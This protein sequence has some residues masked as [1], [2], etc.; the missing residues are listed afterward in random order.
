MSYDD[1]DHLARGRPTPSTPATGSGGSPRSRAPTSS[2]CRATTRRF[3]VLGA[4]PPP[5]TCRRPTTPTSSSRTSSSTGSRSPAPRPTTSRCP[6]TTTS[7]RAAPSSRRRTGILGTRYSPADHLRQRPVLLARPSRRHR[8]ARPP[9]WSRRAV[10]LQPHLARRPDAR[11]PRRRRHR[12]RAGAR[13]TS[14]GTSVTHASEY[15]LQVGTQPNFTVGTFESCRVAGTTYT[16]G[17]VRRQHHRHPRPAATNEDCEPADRR[18]STTGG[19][20]RSTARSRKARR[21]PGRAGPLLR[22]PGLLLPAPAASPTCRPPAGDR[23]RADPHVGPGHRR[24]DLRGQDRAAQRRQVVDQRRRT[25]PSYTPAGHG[26]ARPGRQPV[27][28]ARHGHQHQGRRVRH[29]QQLTFNVS[30]NLPTSG[31]GAL[32]PLDPDAVHARHH[33]RAVADVGADAGRR[34]TTRSTSATAADTDQIWFGHAATDLF[35][36]SVPYPAMTDTSPRLLLPGDVRLAG[37]RLRPGQPRDRHGA[38]GPFHRRSRSRSTT[39]HAVALRRPAARRQLRRHRRTPC[40]PGDRRCTVPSTPVLKWTPDPRV[41]VLHGLRQRGRQLHQPAGAE[42][43]ASRRRPTPCT[44][45]TLD[46][47]RLTPT[48]TA[49]P[50]RRLLLAHP[51]VPQPARTADPTRCRPTDKAQ[52]TLHEALAA[53][54][55]SASIDACRHRDHLQRGTTTSTPTSGAT[56]TLGA[57]RREPRRRRPSST[58][59]RSTTTRRSPAAWSTTASWTRPTYTAFDGL[60]PEGTLFWRVQA[61][62]SDDNGLAWSAR[63]AQH[64]SFIKASPQVTLTSPVD[65]ATVAGTTPF[66]WAPQAFASSYDIEVYKNND[67]TYST[68]NRVASATGAQDSRLRPDR[69]PAAVERTP[70][71]LARAP[72]RTPTATRVRGPRPDGS[73]GQ[74]GRSSCWPRLRTAVQCPQRAG[75]AVAPCDGARNYDVTVDAAATGGT[76]VSPRAPW[77]RRTPPQ[78]ELR[79]RRPTGGR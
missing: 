43:R 9:P 76:S 18:A 44:R 66:R 73:R 23:R 29:L 55:R 12:G 6:P 46:N 33:D 53:G 61:I 42:Q 45:P 51:A 16:P 30:G 77:P 56:A 10:Q 5:I 35:G 2:P 58:A 8:P 72:R 41:A 17:H 36:Q 71:R 24:R 11:L 57:D 32:T 65:N 15:E 62:D 4:P 26:P 27:H 63:T 60:Y 50:A 78:V 19:C 28:L 3:I 64:H 40:T 7:A 34:T 13:C 52:G 59:S 38:R 54:H 79:D 22:D 20:A 14:S 67:A 68:A 31:A 74:P 25:P 48:P 37:D 47:R 1:E 75:P 70:Y 21:H 49:R 69:P 39:G